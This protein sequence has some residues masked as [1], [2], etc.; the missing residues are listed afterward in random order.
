MEK[1]LKKKKNDIFHRPVV[2]ILYNCDKKINGTLNG[3]GSNVLHGTINYFFLMDFV[4]SDEYRSRPCLRGAGTP[5]I[6]FNI[7]IHK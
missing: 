4:I 7:F 6:F 2:P 1:K 5:P 3:S